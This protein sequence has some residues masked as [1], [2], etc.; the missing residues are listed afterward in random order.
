ME[1]EV[2]STV[3]ANEKV[4]LPYPNLEVQ[5]VT[6]AVALV[7]S[8]LDKGDLSVIGTYEGR[9]YRIA[10][11]DKSAINIWKLAR[12]IPVTLNRSST[13]STVLRTSTDIVEACI[14]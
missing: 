9:L 1:Q 6:D 2:L 5:A 13:D 8:G 3:T 4:Q 10:S 11:I 7:L 12:V 14:T